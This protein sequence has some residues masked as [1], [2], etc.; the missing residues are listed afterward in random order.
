MSPS[1]PAT[2]KPGPAALSPMLRDE[3]DD[4][5]LEEVTDWGLECCNCCSSLSNS[6][7]LLTYSCSKLSVCNTSFQEN[8]QKTQI[9][10]GTNQDLETREINKQ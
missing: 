4:G 5:A 10:C 2:P 3:N 8:H 7:I 9:E 6:W 1:M